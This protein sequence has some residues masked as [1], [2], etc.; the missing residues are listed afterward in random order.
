MIRGA[1]G[2][3]FKIEFFQQ[4]M[5]SCSFFHRWE[6]RVKGALFFYKKRTFSPGFLLVLFP[7]FV[8]LF[9]VVLCSFG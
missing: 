1:P 9:G 3:K 5:K 6:V 7:I 2:D 4:E 8:A